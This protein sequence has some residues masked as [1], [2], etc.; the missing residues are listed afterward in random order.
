MATQSESTIGFFLLPW[1]FSWP[2]VLFCLALAALYIR[3]MIVWR[4]GGRHTGIFRPLAFFVG[5]GAIYAV[6]QTR[7]DYLAQF[8]FF[9]HRG[10]HLVLHHLG[11]FLVALSAPTAVMASGLPAAVTARWNSPAGVW[12]G[13]AAGLRGTYRVLQHPLLAPLLFVGLIYFWLIPAVH[14]DAM[15]SARLYQLMNWSMLIDGLL[16]W[17]L[18]LDPRSRDQGALGY[19]HRITILA[20]I[21]PPQIALGAYI[22]FSRDVLFDIYSVC[23][24]AWPLE[25]L[26][27]QQ[28]GG[29]V[30]W[31]PAAMM[32]L[33]GVLVVLRYLLRGAP[34]TRTIPM[35]RVGGENAAT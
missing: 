23:G 24:R 1:E 8:L 19:G 29:I 34:M 35:H 3:G 28:L 33:L 16:F 6:T 13:M 9:A 14:F 32:S 17:W 4:R 18:M 12:A 11:P 31:I 25:P 7:Y 27:D 10:Q 15:L 26:T 20:I 5:L 22:T 21:V 2:W 30:T